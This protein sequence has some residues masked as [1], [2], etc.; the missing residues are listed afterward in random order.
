M[1][2]DAVILSCCCKVIGCRSH[3]LELVSEN[4]HH[5]PECKEEIT[6][7]LI[8]SLPVLDKSIQTFIPQEKA[9]TELMNR[10]STMPVKPTPSIEDPPRESSKNR[11]R[12]RSR[13]T[14]HR[15]DSSRHHSSHRHDRSEH[16]SHRHFIVC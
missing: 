16:R 15:H 9:V 14:S 6:V 10:L 11:D 2:E 3:I 8:R 5:C 7:N 1:I 4:D 12:S 13:H